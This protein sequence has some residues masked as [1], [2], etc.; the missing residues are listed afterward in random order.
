[1]ANVNNIL[2][3]ISDLMRGYAKPNEMRNFIT[4]ICYVLEKDEEAANKLIFEGI[5]GLEDRYNRLI[6]EKNKKNIDILDGLKNSFIHE[7]SHESFR[8]IVESLLLYRQS[9]SYVELILHLSNASDGRFSGE[10]L[11][12]SFLNELIFQLADIESKD[13]V[14]DPTVGLG[15]TLLPILNQNPNQECFGQEL[16]SETMAIAQIIFE[17][18]D[19]RKTTIAQGDVLM[20]PQYVENG[21]LTKFDKVLTIP[22]FGM[23]SNKKE[24]NQD[25]FN[26]FPFGEI[27]K[28]Q[29]DWAF[30]SNAISSTK[31][32]G[33]TIIVVPSGALFRSG[34]EQKIR[35]RILQADLF[36]AIISLP[37]GMLQYTAIPTNILIF[38]KS[39][40]KNRKNNVLFI[41]VPE[42]EVQKERTGNKLS[43]NVIEKIINCYQKYEEISDFSKIIDKKSV[44]AESMSVERY[45][46]PSTYQLTSGTF[47]VQLDKFLSSSNIVPLGQISSI[48]RGYNMIAKNESPDG[49][50]QI[51]RISD[52][53]EGAVNFSKIIR[54]N[55]EDRTKVDNYQLEKGDIILSIRG[56]TNKI[57]ILDEVD[58][59][60]LLHTNLVRIR[61]NRK[62]YLPEYVK[63]FMESPV[64]LAQFE[65]ISQ[66]ST[67]KQLSV[68]GLKNYQIPKIAIERQQQIVQEY[69]QKEQEL[70][71]KIEELM[72]L[73]KENTQQLYKNMGISQ[74]FKQVKD[75]K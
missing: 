62:Y 71:V 28:G 67:V 65:S 34:S 30:I 9:N 14:L 39:K 22:P 26:R 12:P 48:D 46:I 17:L 73:Q 33:K 72:T 58:S 8:R 59:H 40:E 24:L 52:I 43:E 45:I 15:G 13:T 16:N 21:K 66:G 47:D 38:N 37:A 2:Y 35:E 54:G 19:A 61:V 5:E 32:D 69:E 27:P 44:D 36:E 11:T 60:T 10:S 7:M 29:A 68:V 55:I 75:M 4:V 63:L 42:K 41:S 64:G 23:R 25:R 18:S 20:N 53:E 56:T 49:K 31:A 6:R 50:Y 57:A 1:M 74:L 51:V 3:E 70:K